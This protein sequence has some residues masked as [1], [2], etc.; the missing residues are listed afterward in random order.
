[1]SSPTVY[2]ATS[3]RC[4]ETRDVGHL[5]RECR[6]PFTRVGE[7]IGL[8]RGGRIEMRYHIDCLSRDADP[9]SQPGSSFATSANGTLVSGQAPG[10]MFRKMR[11]S[12]HF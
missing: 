5:C 3:S 9:R 12:S 6:Q 11:T 2:W 4:C 10:Q 8:R 7:V 1:M